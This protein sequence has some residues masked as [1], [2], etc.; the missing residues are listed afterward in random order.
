MEDKE[1]GGTL[2]GQQRWAE[3]GI[4]GSE[5]GQQAVEVS[6]GP[7]L[8]SNSACRHVPS[9]RNGA[10]MSSV[11]GNL[12]GIRVQRRIR[13]GLMPLRYWY[14]KKLSSAQCSTTYSGGEGWHRSVMTRPYPHQ[15][16]KGMG[17][18]PKTEVDNGHPRRKQKS[19]HPPLELPQ[20]PRRRFPRGRQRARPHNSRLLPQ[21]RRFL[22]PHCAD[23]GVLPPGRVWCSFRQR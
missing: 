15:G 21:V 14:P 20:G 1:G 8:T 2:Y 5:E 7:N 9:P 16:Q 12:S 22:S 10:T 18:R 17:P 23:V 3:M 11:T 4:P 6:A 19:P 13:P